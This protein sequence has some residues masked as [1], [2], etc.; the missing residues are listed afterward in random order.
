MTILGASTLALLRGATS[1]SMRSEAVA[2]LGCV[3]GGTAAFAWF[4]VRCAEINAG[5]YD[6]GSQAEAQTDA[7]NHLGLDDDADDDNPTSPAAERFDAGRADYDG[8]QQ[9]MLQA[10]TALLGIAIAMWLF[11]R[12]ASPP[13]IF[14]SLLFPKASHLTCMRNG[15]PRHVSFTHPNI[16][17]AHGRVLRQWRDQQ[18]QFVLLEAQDA[19]A[20]TRQTEWRGMHKLLELQKAAFIGVARPLEPYVVVFLIFGIPSIVMATDF[21]QVCAYNSMWRTER[22]DAREL[23]VDLFLGGLC[24]SEQSANS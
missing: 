12:S 23:N 6:T 8:L 1:F 17:W 10:W 7:Y 18:H 9:Q 14:A 4:Y 20:T 22:V 5:G 2:H 15:F 21:C 3:L 19:W 24:T 16:R 13:C 11:L